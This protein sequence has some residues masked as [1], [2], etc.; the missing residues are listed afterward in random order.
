MP[1]P[2]DV[3][4]IDEWSAVVSKV[5]FDVPSVS[6]LE[7]P[8][9]LL[10]AGNTWPVST[11]AQSKRALQ[12]LHIKA[13]IPEKSDQRDARAAKGSAGGRSSRL[14]AEVG[15]Q[16]NTT[17]QAINKL[18][19]F[20]AL[21]LRSGVAVPGRCADARRCHHRREHRSC[22]ARPQGSDHGELSVPASRRLIV[23]WSKEVDSGPPVQS[24][25]GASPLPATQT[26]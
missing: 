7:D 9:G 25:T 8:D 10:V 22:R 16:P 13:D 1:S 12:R 21:A 19:A 15:N 17:E 23:S 20:R 24:S 11:R 4:G 6:V 26:G 5:G 18:T 14:D 2:G 3:R